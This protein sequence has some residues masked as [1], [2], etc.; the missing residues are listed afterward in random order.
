MRNLGSMVLY[1]TVA[2][3]TA[4]AFWLVAWLSSRHL[5]AL[6]LVPMLFI[7][8]F[9]PFVGAAITTFSEGG[10]RRMLRRDLH[11]CQKLL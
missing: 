9:G 3:T 5:T 2:F 7:G 10:V 11:V 8:S 6:P 4:W 1:L